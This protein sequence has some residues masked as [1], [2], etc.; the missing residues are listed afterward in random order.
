MSEEEPNDV[1]VILLGESGI[2]K[3]SLINVTVGQEFRE[4]ENSTASSSFVTKKFEKKNKIYILNIWDTAG[5]EKFRAMTKLFIKNSKIVIFVYSIE[6]RNSFNCLPFW[7]STV[8]EILND[9]PILA[10]IG[11]KSDLYLQETVNSEEGEKYAKS[12]NA[13]F[14]TV[15]AK[16]NPQ[17]FIDFLEQL[18]DEYLEIEGGI[19]KQPSFEIKREQYKKKKKCCQ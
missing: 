5:Q 13:K 19:V 12:I 16:A 14:Q 8:K 9:E 11:N 1:K 6:S 15:S 3:T 18:L 10:V 7:V 4:E 17:G 2:G